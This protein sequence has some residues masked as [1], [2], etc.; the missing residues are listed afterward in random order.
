MKSAPAHQVSTPDV[1]GAFFV[2]K[3]SRSSSTTATPSIP[4]RS[5]SLMLASRL[6]SCNIAPSRFIFQFASY[7]SHFSMSA[8]LDW[9]SLIS[10]FANQSYCCCVQRPPHDVQLTSVCPLS[11]PRVGCPQSSTGHAIWQLACGGWN[12]CAHYAEAKANGTLPKDSSLYTDPMRMKARSDTA[13][14]EEKGIMNRQTG[15]MTDH[16]QE[17]TGL[18]ERPETPR[19]A[20]LPLA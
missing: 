4:A 3:I 2:F 5:V 12:S 15:Q 16:L 19:Q 20:T 18:L 1:T 8:S 6:T 17:A 9:W 13:S 11:M 7:S 10:R 14:G